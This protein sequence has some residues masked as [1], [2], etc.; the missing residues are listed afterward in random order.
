M[1]YLPAIPASS[2]R[3]EIPIG[4]IIIGSSHTAQFAVIR[5]GVGDT[6]ATTFSVG[7]LPF[8][9]RSLLSPFIARA[10]AKGLNYK[11]G[12]GKENEERLKHL[13]RR[14]QSSSVGPAP[15][16]HLY[17]WISPS[18][19]SLLLV[20]PG[21]WCERNAHVKSLNLCEDELLLPYFYVSPQSDT[22]NLPIPS[23]SISLL[24]RSYLGDIVIGPKHD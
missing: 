21:T 12:R 7:A 16:I 8:F 10:G 17:R 3:K 14:S 19:S 11:E 24:T 20:P 2:G 22:N 5:T 4:I 23:H 18:N 6:S 1:S 9:Q 13:V 15:S